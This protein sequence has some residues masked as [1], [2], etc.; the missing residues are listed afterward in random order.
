MKY[1]F[2]FILTLGLIFGAYKTAQNKIARPQELAQLRLGMT[3]EQLEKT[4]GT[5]SAQARNQLTYILDD[6]SELFVTLRDNVVSSAT[7]RFH[8]NRQIQ[9]PDLKNLTLVQMDMHESNSN[10]PSWFFAG[11]PAEGLIYKVT[12]QGMVESLTWVPPFTYGNNRAKHLQ[13][14]LQ[15]FRSQQTSKL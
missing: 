5:P 14:L 7:A 2:F 10:S 4:F 15:D 8:Q 3:I 1:G 6:G 12:T 13:A 9:D 11:N